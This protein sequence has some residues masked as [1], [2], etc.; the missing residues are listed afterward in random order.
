M[1]LPFSK[2][3]GTGNDFIIINDI[4]LGDKGHSKI[5]GHDVRGICSRHTG[6]GAD[7]LIFLTSKDG[8]DFEMI[9]Y[10]SDGNQSS[11]CG[12]GGR[13]VTAFAKRVGIINDTANF[14]AVDGAHSAHF[15]NEL[16]SLQMQNVN[17]IQANDTFFQLDTGSPHYVTFV[18]DV[19][20]I[21]VEQEGALIRNSPMFQADGINVNFVEERGNNQL[22][23]RTYERGVEGETLSCGTGVT[24]AALVQMSRNGHSEINVE[25]LGG[26]LSVKAQPTGGA[27]NNIELIGPAQF[28][29]D[30]QFEIADA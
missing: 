23:V 28:V 16:I 6:V 21:N 11:M 29:F 10:N 20:A 18:D 13:C 5:K 2:Y 27:F 14:M 15:V 19:E 8:F 30:G 1:I 3:Q 22:F 12:N 26:Q 17:Q 7:G 9:Y 4:P 24:A 25:T